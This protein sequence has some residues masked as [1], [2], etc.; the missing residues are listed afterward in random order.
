M[1]CSRWPSLTSL[2]VFVLLLGCGGGGGEEDDEVGETTDTSDTGTDTTGTDTSETD[3]S[4]TDTSETDTSNEQLLG[5]FEIVLHPNQPMVVDV[6]VELT[7]PGYATLTHLDDPGVKV[8]RLDGTDPAT[9]IHLRVRGLLPDTA[10][11]LELGLGVDEGSPSEMHPVELTTNPA[12]PGFIAAFPLT[13]NEAAEVDSDYRFFDLSPV[14]TAGSPSM[15]MIDPVGRTRWH[16]GVEVPMIDLDDL[17]VGLKLRDDGSVLA[18]WRHTAL[19]YDELGEEQ[20]RVEADADLGVHYFHHELIE[21]PNGNFM[22]LSWSFQDIEYEGEGVLHVGGD[23]LVEFSPEGE[24]VWTWDTFD[25]LDPQRRR[26]GFFDAYPI[27]DPVTNENAYDWTHAN[28]IVYADGIIYVSLRHQDWIL[29]I[30]HAT[31]ELLWRLGDEGDFALGPD[32]TWF[33][34]QHSPE[35]QPDGSLLLYDN[36]VGNPDQP[37]SEAHSRAVR[38]ALDF[39]AM[40][41]TQVWQDDDETFIS[42]IAG[43]ADR[44][45]SGHVLRLDSTL[46]QGLPGSEM[47]YSRLRE[48]DPERTPNAVWSVDLPLGKFAYRALPLDR[49]VGESVP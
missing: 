7:S 11:S 29:A 12:G 16:L 30:D 28:G 9:S 6:L 46:G 23:L 15:Y 2:G 3:T 22:A 32:S 18:M 14:F 26:A 25:Y 1:L 27:I 36:A 5:D 41:A 44:T 37:D 39:D 31:G 47:V 42:A 21:L 34:H 49:L 4:E 35:W 43:D 38:Y 20:L 33:F 17:W 19:I 8:A 24:L 10:H 13:L 40:T 45:S 48:L